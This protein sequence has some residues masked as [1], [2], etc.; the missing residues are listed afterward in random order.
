MKKILVVTNKQIITEIFG[1][2]E[3]PTVGKFFYITDAQ[4]EEKS[5][6]RPE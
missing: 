4:V 6:A 3:N 2:T 5:P 1:T